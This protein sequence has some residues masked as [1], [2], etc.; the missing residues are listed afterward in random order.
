GQNQIDIF[1][2][3]GL[4]KGRFGFDDI[5]AKNIYGNKFVLLCEVVIEI[6][7][8]TSM[9]VNSDE[10]WKARKSK[11]L[12]SNIYDGEVYDATFSGSTIYSVKEIDLGF[13]KLKPR[14]S[15]P[16]KIKERLKPI[17]IIT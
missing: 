6:K 12:D 11:I 15:L 16:V 3:N 10:T 9:V 13:D 7:D 14:L 4:Y 2:G 8:G 5:N 17:K 1:L